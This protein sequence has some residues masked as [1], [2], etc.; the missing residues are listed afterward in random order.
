[1]H[2][3]EH[4]PLDAFREMMG[5]QKRVREHRRFHAVLLAREGKTAPEIARTL[6]C[7]R[8]LVQKWV[9]RYNRGGPAALSEGTHSGRPP[10]LAADQE[11][12]LRE[13]IDA[14]PR[15]DDGTCAFH[16]ED[17]RRILEREFDVL[18]KLSAVYELLH[19]L[20]YSRLCPRPRHPD[21]DPA[22]QDAFK[23][24]RGNES[25]R[26]RSN[27]RASVW[28]RGSRTKP[29]SASKAR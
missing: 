26:S 20:G 10:R 5:G 21:A 11:Q 3:V 22:A 15:P 25:S 12:R 24:T 23:K 18:L 14:G 16:G 29:A 17:L 28:K 1:M 27:T 8:R 2:V 7:A 13:R 4:E 6:G 9:F 19:R